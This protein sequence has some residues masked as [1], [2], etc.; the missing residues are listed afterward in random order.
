MSQVERVKP[1]LQFV[2]ELQKVGGDSL[3][4]C[5]QCAT[6]SVVCPISPADDPYPRKE[7]VWAQWGLKDRLVND[8]DIWL[9]HNCGDCSDLCP[10]G[11]K[12]GDLLAAL[13]NM[14]YRKLVPPS[15]IGT[16]MSSPVFLPIL[17]AIPAVIYLLIWIAR[18]ATLGT[19]FPLFKQVG[20]KYV[21]DPAG[22]VIY[23][24]LF[25]GDFTIDPVFGA[26]AVIVLIC[27]YAGIKKLMNAFEAMPKT[28]VVGQTK[29]PS[30]WECL[31]ETVKH[32]IA[33]HSRFKQCGADESTETRVKGHM[34][35]FYA[36]I[37]LF[38]VTTAVA[39]G[40]WGGKIPGLDFL[41]AM[42][43]TPM[44][45]Y[46]PIKILALAGGV[47]L[48]IGLYK[49]TKRR[50]NLDADK[51]GSNYYDWYLLGVIWAL[52][53]TGMLCVLLRW[54]NLPVLAYP[55]YYLHLISVWMLIAYLPWSKLG[56]LVYRTVALAYAR[57]IGRL[58]MNY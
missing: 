20:H 4:K 41:H 35:T 53:V 14:A 25:P 6:C 49:L 23:G 13:R 32:E 10:R 33:L 45:L 31:W 55:V 8:I 30:F 9:C 17:V 36:F 1:D 27:F 7:M 46:N 24:G 12:P 18:A 34:L 21:Q 42:G 26:V 37:M 5:Y 50:L 47:L 56:H 58:P 43:A 11:A 48:L 19:A 16:W 29:Q 39:I 15:I 51:H 52:G 40:H 22:E 38:I 3:K 57:K 28:F 54:A 2:Q 44:P